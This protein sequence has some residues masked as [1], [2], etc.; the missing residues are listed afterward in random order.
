M[1]KT[2]FKIGILLVLI[3]VYTKTSAQFSYQN[4]FVQYDSLWTFRKLSLIP[5]KFKGDGLHVND[6]DLPKNIIS[7]KEALLSGKCAIK[8]IKINKGSD[9]S[10]LVLKNK[11]GKTI[12][13]NAGEIVTGGKQDRITGEA[14]FISPKKEDQYLSVFCAEKG[15]WDDKEKPFH[16]HS[17]ADM[18]VKKK[19]DI[20]HRQ[21]EVWKEIAEQFNGNK[22]LSETFAYASLLKKNQEEEDAYKAFFIEK[23]KH[24]DSTFSGFIAVTGNRIIACELFSMAEYC[25]K[26][27][28]GMVLSFVHSLKEDDGIP[29]LHRNSIEH[30]ADELLGSE[31]SQKKMLQSSGKADK[32][33]G[34]IFHLIAYGN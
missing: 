34:K 26:N 24:S 18:G 17:V 33:Q 2:T 16:Y 10:V 29:S 23:L 14:T 30:F 12:F 21:T 7:F 3:V 19:I 22:T 27:Y 4:L 32:W 20:E 28:D 25:I 15:R 1:C 31:D 8:E 6:A 13:I 5:V 9:V 11:T